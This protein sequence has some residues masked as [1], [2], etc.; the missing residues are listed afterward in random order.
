MKVTI[1]GA[2][3]VG[4]TCAKV[5]ANYEIADE[6]LLIDIK[7]GLAEG[8]ALDMWETSPILLYDTKTSGHTG[9]YSKTYDSEVVVITSGVPRSPGMSRDDLVS[10][11]A[12][13][14]KEVTEQVIRYS[15]RAK[16]IVVSNPLDVMTYTSYLTAKIPA[17]RIFGMAGVLDAARLK[18]FIALELNVSPK[19]INSVL[20]GGHG[21]TMVPLPRYTTVGGIPITELMS[22]G[23]I[24]AIVDRTINGG[25]EI[26]NLIGTSAWYAPGAAA[27]LMVE[28]IL[29]NQRRILPIS[30]WLQGEYGLQ[31]IYFGVPAVLGKN[32]VEE[33][34]ELQLTKK[35]M[36]LVKHS[37]K[38]VKNVQKI[39]DDMK[40][41]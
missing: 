39:L 24:N 37:A 8:K 29:R 40:L 28:T 31:D 23:Q 4:A 25:A 34:I 2:G 17:K 13:I 11:N 9:D 38:A 15:P 6:I 19:E 18:S 41:F 33:I 27:A 10:I 30:C 1:V 26:V 14:V 22:D 3:N 21:D 12:K 5:L 36:E 7:K 32:G 20:L 35:E 16:I